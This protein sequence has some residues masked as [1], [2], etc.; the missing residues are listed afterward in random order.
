[1]RKV[2]SVVAIPGALALAIGAMAA[3][4]APAAEAATVVTATWTGTLR[5]DPADPDG[6]IDNAGVFGGGPLSLGAAFTLTTTFSTA[7]GTY[8]AG[9]KSIAGG[10]SSVLEINGQKF[11]IDTQPSLYEISGDHFV[12]DFGDAAVDP[13][14]LSA[15]FDPKN[16]LPGSILSSFSDVCYQNTYCSGTFGITKNGKF[17]GAGFDADSLVVDVAQV[18]QTPIP[19][20]LPLFLSALLGL[21]VVVR[22]K[23]AI[24]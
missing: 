4:A 7:T 15:N 24:D 6:N 21:G 9:S 14:S 12:L 23:T 19:A 2:F 22:R 1:M 18:A 13:T 11:T 20:T 5:G 17:S 16:G 8:S 3:I 10:G